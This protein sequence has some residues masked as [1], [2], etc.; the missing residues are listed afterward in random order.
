[1]STEPS[2][3]ATDLE[4]LSFLSENARICNR[5]IAQNLGLADKFVERLRAQRNF[6]D[7]GRQLDGGCS[8]LR[9]GLR[10]PPT[11]QAHR[12]SRFQPRHRYPAR[13]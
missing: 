8:A 6:I 13:A 10:L 3:D 4:I 11:A 1:M 2:L 5:E 9:H 7:I 12:G